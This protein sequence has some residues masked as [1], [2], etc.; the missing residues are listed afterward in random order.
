M[1]RRGE[2]TIGTEDIVNMLGDSAI[3]NQRINA[4]N[5]RSCPTF[6]APEGRYII[7]ETQG[8]DDHQGT[9]QTDTELEMHDVQYRGIAFV[10]L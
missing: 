10:W 7:E 5:A 8:K 3:C 1:R 9:L 2:L 6:H 4:S